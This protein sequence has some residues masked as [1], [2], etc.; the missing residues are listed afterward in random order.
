MTG[1]YPISDTD[2][3]PR[4]LSAENASNRQGG[5]RRA[6]RVNPRFARGVRGVSGERSSG[7]GHAAACLPRGSTSLPRVPRVVRV[8]RHTRA[9]RPRAHGSRRPCSRKRPRRSATRPACISGRSHRERPRRLQTSTRSQSSMPSISRAGSTDRRDVKLPS[10]PKGRP[11][12]S[13]RTIAD[14]ARRD[15]RERLRRVRKGLRPNALGHPAA[16][17]AGPAHGD[18]HDHGGQVRVVRSRHPR[19]RTGVS[20]ELPSLSQE[21]YNEGRVPL[22]RIAF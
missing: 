10:Y 17:P 20:V 1:C 19:G 4:S 2:D 18:N 21:R 6:L 16:R 5:L 8:P 9:R 11:R 7:D 14:S 12:W 3:V 15:G 22:F 13:F